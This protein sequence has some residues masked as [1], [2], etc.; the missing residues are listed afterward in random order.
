VQMRMSGTVWARRRVVDSVP[1]EM[2]H[3]TQS[4]KGVHEGLELFEQGWTLYTHPTEKRLGMF[5]VTMRGGNLVCIQ[6]L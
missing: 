4:V 2:T 6:H 1:R 3:E 5:P